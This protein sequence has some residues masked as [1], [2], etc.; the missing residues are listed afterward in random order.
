MANSLAKALNYGSFNTKTFAY[1]FIQRASGKTIKNL[2]EIFDALLDILA[3]RFDNDMAK[4]NDE[5][6]CAVMAKRIQDALGKY[7]E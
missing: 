4:D 6:D 2:F 1:H 7:K 3:E 5:Y